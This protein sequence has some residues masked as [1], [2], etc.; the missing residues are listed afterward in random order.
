MYVAV[1][2]DAENAKDAVG[3]GLERLVRGLCR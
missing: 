3:T 2:E 1:S